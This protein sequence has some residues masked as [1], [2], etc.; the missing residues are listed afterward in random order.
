VSEKAL[1][2][3]IA[4]TL[5]KLQGHPDPEAYAARAEAEHVEDTQSQVDSAYRA[6][7]ADRER[8]DTDNEV[9]SKTFT[10]GPPP[11]ETGRSKGHR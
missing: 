5:A 11:K 6:D 7:V 8:E 4:L 10:P 1:V 9:V 2:K 3:R